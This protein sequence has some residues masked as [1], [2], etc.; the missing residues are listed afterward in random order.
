MSRKTKRTDDDIINAVKENISIRGVLQ[1]LNL[2]DY[3]GANYTLIKNHVKRLNLDTSHWT[4]QSHLKGKNHSWGIKKPLNEILV[5]N[6]DYCSTST[7][8]LKKRLLNEGVMINKCYECGIIE[9]RGKNISLHID[10]INGIRSDN[11]MENLRLLCPNCHSQTPTYCGRN[12][13]NKLS[14]EEKIIKRK[15]YIYSGKC[16]LCGGDTFS[17]KTRT[18]KKCF[19]K[20]RKTKINWPSHEELDRLVKE[21]GYSYTSR[22]L[23]VSDNAIR[24]HLR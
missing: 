16:E 3:G 4:G 15:S 9:W 7:S 6:S 12:K 18:C 19:N 23:G 24:K 14:T 5:E 22:I 21:N 17:S 2:C 8:A 10:H 1:Q 11:R 13:K 20:N